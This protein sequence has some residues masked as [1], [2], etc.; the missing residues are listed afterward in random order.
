[1]R[2][3]DWGPEYYL[4]H[5]QSSVNGHYFCYSGQSAVSLGGL[6][7]VQMPCFLLN[8]P[9]LP[10]ISGA[11]STSELTGMGRQLLLEREQ[12]KGTAERSPGIYMQLIKES[13]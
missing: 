11:H 8:M 6:T 3:R 12:M 2:I 7:S 5:G 1:M 9:F 13:S 10:C 4:A